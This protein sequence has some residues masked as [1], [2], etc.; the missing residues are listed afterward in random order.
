MA[1][2]DSPG[3]APTEP[4]RIV[5]GATERGT[6]FKE[7]GAAASSAMAAA[8]ACRDDTYFFADAAS[9][10]LLTLLLSSFA[11]SPLCVLSE[12]GATT[13]TGFGRVRAVS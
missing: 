6:E 11:F 8:A 2:G 9:P 5:R 1:R 4:R 12:I 3:P 10:V 13:K 7:E